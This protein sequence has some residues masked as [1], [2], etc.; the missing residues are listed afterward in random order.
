M[1]GAESPLDSDAIEVQYR[2]RLK[3]EK[4]G[5]LRRDVLM[6]HPFEIIG[7]KAHMPESLYWGRIAQTYRTRYINE[8]VRIYYRGDVNQNLSK[9]RNFEIL[10]EGSHRGYAFVL[11]VEI[12]Y[13]WCCVSCFILA[14]IHYVR[15]SW[16]SGHGVKSQVSAVSGHKGLILWAMA[17]P[18]GTLV[19]W[20]DKFR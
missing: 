10:S 15:F 13:F 7:N 1:E 4:M 17:F 14:A 16:H 12:A 9:I 5:F 3:G 8:V 19:F 18:I 6:Q 20:Y 2:Y 11:S